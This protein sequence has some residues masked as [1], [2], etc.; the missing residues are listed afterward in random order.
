[1]TA[2][3]VQGESAPTLGALL[4]RPLAWTI[5]LSVA[6]NLLVLTPA[7]FML[8]VFD[9]VL[10]SRSPETLVVLLAGV[11]VAL[12][13][14]LALDPLKASL[15]AVSRGMLGDALMPAVARR[16]IEQL[17]GYFQSTM[18]PVLR[19]PISSLSALSPLSGSA[20]YQ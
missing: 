17:A 18:P 8:Q 13:L 12:A 1:M 20:Q 6:M 16:Q 7:L 5:G 19:S 3:S 9:R 11:A 10:V 2:P 15:Q 4:R 14:L